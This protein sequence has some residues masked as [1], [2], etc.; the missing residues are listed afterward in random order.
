MASLGIHDTEVT[1]DSIRM[2]AAPL[3]RGMAQP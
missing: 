3:L 1:D 2:R